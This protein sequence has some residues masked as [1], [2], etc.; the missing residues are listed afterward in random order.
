MGFLVSKWK[1]VK[2]ARP[3]SEGVPWWFTGYDLVL[4]L[5]WPRFSPKPGHSPK[6]KSKN[7]KE[8]KSTRANKKDPESKLEDKTM[9]P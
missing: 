9:Y 1:C 5:P 7:K 3:K 2:K 4:S 8:H 6:Q